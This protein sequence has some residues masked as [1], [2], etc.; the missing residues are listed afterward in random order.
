MTAPFAAI[1]PATLSQWFVL[2]R[3]ADIPAA[4]TAPVTLLGEPLTLDCDGTATDAAGRMLETS[5]AYGH[6]WAC[7]GTPAKP[8]FTLPEYTELD[9]RIALCGAVRVRASGLRLVENFLDLA[10]FPF[11]HTGILGAEER[12]EVPPY[13]AEIRRDVDEVWATDCAFWQPQ[14]ALG[15]AD[16]QM[17]DYTYRVATPFNVILYKT[18]PAAPERMDVI[19]LFVQPV[20]PALSRAFALVAVIDASSSETALNHFQQTIFVQD[21]AILE[22]QRPTLLPLDPGAEMPTR[23]DL[24][25]IAYRRWLKEKGVRYG[26]A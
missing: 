10:H 12:P 18:C 19:A 7:P 24:T 2:G 22:N 4:G 1:E 14:A 3:E 5:R 26:T 25:S 8:L 17:S 9:R 6:L 13:K 11:V 20:G 21:R 23:A 15:A 16:G